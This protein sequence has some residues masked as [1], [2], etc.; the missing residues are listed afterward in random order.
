MSN[1]LVLTQK[2]LKEPENLQGLFELAPVR[3]NWIEN[4]SKTS[5]KNDGE[6]RYEAEKILFMQTVGQNKDL[7]NADRFSIYSSFIELAISGLT[8]RDGLTYII[9]YSKRQKKGDDWVD[10]TTAQFQVGWQGRLEQISTMPNVVYCHEPQVVHEGDTFEFEMGM[11]P[12]IHKH[13][14][15]GKSDKITHV[16][17]V[18]EFSHG[19]KVYM[20]SREDVYKVR[21]YSPSYKFYIKN[22][23]VWNKGKKDEKPMDLPMWLSSEAQAFKK[24]IVKRVYKTLPKLPRQ[25]MLDELLEKREEEEENPYNIQ[26]GADESFD[27]ETGEVFTHHEEVKEEK[28]NIVN[29]PNQSF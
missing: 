12:T 1:K 26:M 4:Y 14:P 17:F 16:Y 21:D 11:N 29:D 7:A 8:L 3:Q 6:M 22:D 15:A 5:G 13:I 19:K 24:T 25:K 9:P 2:M 28:K 18:I 20:M 27:A 10:V 23:G